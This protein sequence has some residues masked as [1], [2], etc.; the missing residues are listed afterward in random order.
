MPPEGTPGLHPAAAVGFERGADAY[1]RGRPGF[2]KEAVAFVADRLRLGAGTTLLELGA[3]T[4]KLTRLLEPT[5]ARIVGVEPVRAMRSALV[6]SAPTAWAIGALA[7]KLPLADASADAAVAAQAFHWFDGDR[8]LR[9]LARVLRNG[10]GVALVWNVRDETVGWVRDIARIIEPY[11]GDTPT[12]RSLR[13]KRAFESTDAFTAPAMRSFRYGHVTTPA[14][15]VDRMCSISFVAALPD[16][17]RVTIADGVRRLLEDEAEADDSGSIVF[18]YRT[19]VWMSA[20][21]RRGQA[22]ATIT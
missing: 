16:P 21:S 10:A 20:K 17:K 19:D 18:P 9:E 13:W 12:H 4:G 15:V 1:E 7:E 11:R 2:P 3:G 22:S 6:A 8:A 14:A 5:C